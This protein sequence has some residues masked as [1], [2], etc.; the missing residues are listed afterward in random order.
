[1]W[2]ALVEAIRRRRAPPEALLSEAGLGE[3]MKVADIGAGYGFF[4][5]SAAKV[6]G[7]NGV[8]YA[9]E[10]NA[11]RAN[12][13]SKRSGEAETKNL[14]VLVTGAEELGEIPPGEIDLA[15]SVSSFHHFADAEKA[16]SEIDR[17]V[18]LGGRVYIRDIKA[19]RVFR[20]G[21][22]SETFRRLVS[23]RFPMAEFEEGR[24]YLVARITR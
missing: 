8:V 11:T 9:V 18:R 19:G 12:E 20:H 5:L 1:M 3:G 13:I 23:S 21:S 6:V 15:L 2:S 22:R 10:P 24:G 16:L 14:R 7:A 17:V 4:A